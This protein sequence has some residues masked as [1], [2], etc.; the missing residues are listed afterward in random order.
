MSTAPSIGENVHASSGQKTAGGLSNIRQDLPCI[1][2]DALH[3][4]D[5]VVLLKCIA[6]VNADRV[7]PK[8]GIILRANSSRGIGLAVHTT[9]ASAGKVPTQGSPETAGHIEKFP[10]A[11]DGRQVVFVSPAVGKGGVGRRLGQGYVLEGDE[12]RLLVGFFKIPAIF[13]GDVYQPDLTPG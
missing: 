12:E 13:W 5:L 11:K 1:L 4:R 2:V 3:E 9:G 10:L 8:D 6:L 7:G